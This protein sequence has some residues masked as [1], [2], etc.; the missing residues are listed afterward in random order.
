MTA[1][2][3]DLGAGRAA[4]G[5]PAQSLK[6]ARFGDNMRYVAVTEGDKTEAEI[7]LRASRSTPGASTT[8]RTPSTPP[9]THGIDALVAEYDDRYDVAPELRAGGERHDS[10]R[11]GAAIELGPA[12]LPRGR[13]LRRVHHHLRGPRRPARSSPAWPCSG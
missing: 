13:R 4:A 10:L 3:G 2:V 5:P 8:W 6:L 7:R 1:S 9:A 11:Y 12:L